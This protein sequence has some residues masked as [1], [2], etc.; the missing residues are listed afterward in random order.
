MPQSETVPSPLLLRHGAMFTIAKAALGRLAMMVLMGLLLAIL[1]H[2]VVLAQEM[3]PVPDN[4]EKVPLTDPV[5]EG[6]EGAIAD[7]TIDN[8]PVIAEPIYDDIAEDIAIESPIVL[9]DPVYRH[10]GLE[11]HHRHTTHQH[12][13]Q[14]CRH[15][16]CVLPEYWVRASYLNWRLSGMNLPALVT[17]SPA[18]TAR[19][20]AGVLGLSTTSILLGQEDVGDQSRSGGRFEF[21]RWFDRAGQ[22][23]WSVA[24]MEI[25]EDTDSYQFNSS[26]SPIL[27]RPFF[28]L[29]PGFG[30]PNSDLLGQPGEI[31]GNVSVDSSVSFEGAEV[32]FHRLVAHDSDQRLYASLGYQYFGLDDSLRIRDFKQIVG[33]G[34]GLAIGTTIDGADEFSADNQFH[35]VAIGVRTSRKRYRWTLDAGL[36]CALGDSHSQVAISGRTTSSVP[37]VG[38]G[39]DTA[40]TAGG[41]L[42]LP[43]NSGVFDRH[44]LAIVP[45]MDVGLT[46][47]LFPRL[48]G[49]VGYQFLYW[50]KLARSAEQID[51]GVDLSQLDPGQSSVGARPEFEFRYTDLIA[52]GL[53][54]GLE[55]R[56]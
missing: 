50:S 20:D 41:L 10:N 19:E 6:K 52:H 22:L 47:Q 51:T 21:G 30:G 5:V 31:T 3:I 42:A 56:F 35:G 23:G 8:G 1:S 44:E 34:S 2:Q 43:S 18:G 39:T 26:S 4:A 28:S 25:D 55:Y 11:S 33:N 9:G 24:F 54:V 7:E 40:T 12:C 37:Q 29:E 32:M 14:A 13:Q 16:A 36:Q 38:G 48:N 15:V 53:D 46:L 17:S 49:F 27:A 45:Q